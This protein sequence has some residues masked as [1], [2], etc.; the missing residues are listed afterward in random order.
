MKIIGIVIASIVLLL[1]ITF[2]IMYASTSNKEIGLRNRAETQRKKVEI[3]YD[4]MWKIIRDKA[5]VTDNYKDAFKDI[6]TGII[7]GRYDKGDGAL[8]KFVTESNPNFDISL[9]SSLMQSIEA[10][11][12]NFTVAQSAMIDIIREHDNLL[13]KFPSS[14]FIGSRPRIEYTVISSTKSK[15]VMQSGKDDE[16]AF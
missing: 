10:E 9:Y 14:I 11:R 4:Q 1:T 2:G 8:L 15:E 5:K 13:Q 12:N 16:P 3:V 7:S 6:Y